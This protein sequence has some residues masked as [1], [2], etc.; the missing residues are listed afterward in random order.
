MMATTTPLDTLIEQVTS[1]GGTT[2]A[3]L[4]EMKSLGVDHAFGNV[5][6]KAI[7]RA[8]ELSQPTP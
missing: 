3:G 4:A 2:A 8:E 6:L 7:I 1:P 5:V